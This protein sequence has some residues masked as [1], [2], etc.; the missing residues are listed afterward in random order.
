MW[1]TCVDL[2]PAYLYQSRTLAEVETIKA[3]KCRGRVHKGEFERFGG[4]YSITNTH[5]MLVVV[6]Q[7]MCG[8]SAWTV[9]PGNWDTSSIESV[10]RKL[11]A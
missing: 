11:R 4:A 8:V 7:N 2:I 5:G 1:G 10:R 6:R 9:C 3:V